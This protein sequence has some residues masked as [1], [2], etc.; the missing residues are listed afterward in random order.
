MKTI[1]LKCSNCK[2]KFTKDL[3]SYT[4]I[5]RKEIQNSNKN[6]FCSKKCYGEFKQKYPKQIKCL[7][8]NTIINNPGIK[9]F[10]NHSCA[11]TYN[12]THKTKGT[13][14]SK[15]ELWLQKQLPKK[16]PK[17]EFHFNRKDTINSELDIYI[18]SLN[19]AFELNG[20]FHYE[21]IYGPEKLAQIQNNDERKFQACL[22]RNI[23]LCIIDT[24]KYSYFK[25]STAKQFLDII[26]NIIKSKIGK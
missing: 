14:V 15:L 17:L 16:Y 9:K 10:C 7:N 12:N 8:C 3:Y 24:S 25:E 5:R 22:E 20:P 19:L 2:I 11:A 26:K 4:N 23:S 1:I 13:R 18:P 6:F 21:P